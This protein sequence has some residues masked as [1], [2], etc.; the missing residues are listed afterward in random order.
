VASI[1]L[2]LLGSFFA[3]SLPHWDKSNEVH[4]RPTPFTR[5]ARISLV[6]NR[7]AT[8][9]DHTHFSLLQVELFYQVHC[10]RLQM[11]SNY[12][13][14]NCSFHFI[15]IW[16]AHVQ[17]DRAWKIDSSSFPQASQKAILFICLF[18]RT[19]LAGTN[20]FTTPPK[21]SFN[22]GGADVL[23]SFFQIRLTSFEPEA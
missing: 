4:H 6:P 14:I 8:T 12:L 23:Q 22:F 13:N 2:F 15:P 20:P 5:F 11:Q 21:G 9:W 16:G 17:S 10:P 3:F 1:Y 7:P 19:C 18:L